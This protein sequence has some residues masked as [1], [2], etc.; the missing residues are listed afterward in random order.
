MIAYLSSHIGGSYIKNGTRMPTPLIADNGFLENL[1]QH[2]KNNSNVLIISAA[3]DD[4]EVNDSRRNIFAESFPMSGL[5]INRIIMCDKRNEN[6]LDGKRLFEDITYPDSYGREFYA[7]ADGS[8]FLIENK[9]TTL[10]GEAYLIKDGNIRQ[11]CEKDKSIC[12]K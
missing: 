6:V 9:T 5:S 8:F 7:L 10:F 3:P 11:I 12:I 2:W 1:Q 4:I